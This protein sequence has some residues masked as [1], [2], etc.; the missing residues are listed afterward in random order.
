MENHTLRPTPDALL[1]PRQDA[2]FKAIFS[3]DSEEGRLALKSFL[4]AILNAKVSDIQL[5]QNE[6]PVESEYDKKS[7]F[8]IQQ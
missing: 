2:N 7:V 8:D 5:L 4:E 3:E 1:N 6:L